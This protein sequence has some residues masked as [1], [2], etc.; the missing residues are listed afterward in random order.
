M[1]LQNEVIEF[2]KR[3]NIPDKK[4]LS[5]W[6]SHV[7]L[8]WT[9]SQAYLDFME[10]D[11]VMIENTGRNKG[12][13]PTVKRHQCNICKQ[14]F[15]TG[16]IEIDHLDSE[17]ELTDLSHINAFTK[18]I[19]FTSPDKLQKVCSDR[20]KTVNKKKVLTEFGCHSLKTF[21]ERY[22]DKYSVTTLEQAKS[23][24]TCIELDKRNLCGVALQELGHPVESSKVKC[25]DK[26]IK[27][28]L[29]NLENGNECKISL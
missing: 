25:K 3:F 23:I 24:K 16:N 21:L 17:N 14:W 5:W 8:M 27:V 18:A 11:S 22:G 7:R 20:Y 29:D 10:K 4:L 19:L 2:G 12:R 28:L 9:G 1:N 13:Y 6:R 15:G 26:L